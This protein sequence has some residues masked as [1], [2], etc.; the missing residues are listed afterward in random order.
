M[1]ESMLNQQS[2]LIE[3]V[4]KQRTYFGRSASPEFCW[5]D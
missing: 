5:P 1:R 4:K 3:R 2:L